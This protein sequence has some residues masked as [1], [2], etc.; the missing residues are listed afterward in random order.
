M[1]LMQSASPPRRIGSHWEDVGFQGNDPSTDMRGAGVW[2]LIQLLHFAQS[3]PEL[4]RSILHLS[5]DKTQNFPLAVVSFNITGMV[6]QALREDKLQHIFT[7]Y[8]SG[9]PNNR[10]S[11]IRSSSG[12]DVES[13]FNSSSAKSNANDGVNNTLDDHYASDTAFLEMCMDLYSGAFA[14]MFRQ[15]QAKQRTAHDFDDARKEL[16]AIFRTE[17]KIFI[18][19]LSTI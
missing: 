4:L 1:L 8:Y 5:K 19:T 9:K 3:K 13:K 2:A 16:L 14:Y 17:P 18:K 12:S 15:W 11:F 6:V 10:G 7:K